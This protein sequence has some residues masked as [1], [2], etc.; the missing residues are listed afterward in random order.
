M[1][2]AD[3]LSADDLIRGAEIVFAEFGLSKK[4]VSDA[5]KKFVSDQF[6]PFCRQLN[7]EQAIKSSWHHQINGQVEAYMM[8]LMHGIKNALITI[9]M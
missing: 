1:K 5:G 8:F 9:M 3:G 6:K 4:I 7:I 2:K